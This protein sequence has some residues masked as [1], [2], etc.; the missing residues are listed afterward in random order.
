[1]TSYTKN[2]VHIYRWRE[3]N[4]EHNRIINRNAQTKFRIW[5]N[6]QKVY[7]AILLN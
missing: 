7:L 3:H 2:K 6:I 4:I 5:K 1:M